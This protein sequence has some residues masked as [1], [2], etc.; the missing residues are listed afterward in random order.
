LRIIHT[1][2]WHLG[3]S[4]G[5]ISLR[6]DQEAFADWFVELAAHH[7]A[8]LIV[9]AG[10]LYDR[11]IAPVE[12]IDLFRDTMRR[13]IALGATVAAIT[14]NHDGPDRVAPYSELL[15]VSGVLLRGGYAQAGEI[16]TCDFA[17]GPLDL[18]LIPFLDPQAAPDAFGAH[19]TEDG[20]HDLVERRQRRTHASVLASATAAARAN[21]RS[22]RSLAVAHAYVSGARTSDSERQLV[23]GGTGEVPATLFDGFSYTALGHLH[24]P[25]EAGRPTT[26]YSGTPLAYSFS[27]EH[28]KS[29]TLIDLDPNGTAKIEAITVDVG[30]RVQTITGTMAELLDPQRYPEA[31][32][33]FVR[34]KVTDRETV[35]DARTKLADRYPLIAEVQ[36]LPDGRAPDVGPTPTNVRDLAP[37]DAAREFWTAAQGA[38][39]SA[40][41]DAVLVSATARAEGTAGA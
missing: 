41:V 16:I 38:D 27:E 13:L 39:P 11:A 22:P 5:P 17:D 7:R 25:Q 40:E 12:S 24:K 30:R 9:I 6:S 18:A 23:V 32:A 20:E 3:K 28:E 37:I 34:A 14:G 29:V 4:F 1:S 15:D 21:L 33:R 10:D 35:L 36:L 26:R 8:E 19:G 31:R 2:D